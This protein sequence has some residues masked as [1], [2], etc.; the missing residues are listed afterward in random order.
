MKQRRKF[1]AGLAST[2]VLARMPLRASVPSESTQFTQ[3]LADLAQAQMRR[4]P[5]TATALG[6]DRGSNH[7]LRSRLSDQSLAGRAASYRQLQTEL[8]QL[9]AV[10]RAGLLHQQQID[11][12][13]AL[14]THRSDAA[15]QAFGFGGATFGPT[16][17]VVSQL[18]GA[19]QSIPDFLDTQH[20]IGNKDD[21]EAY[22]HRIQAFGQQVDDQTERMRQDAVLGVVP[23]DFIIDLAIEQMTKTAVP[24][25][26]SLI[27]RSILSR[28]SK[29]GLGGGYATQA[30]AIYAARV[31][32]SL[33]R[34]LAY[35]RALRAK[36]THEAGVWKLP[37]G[38]DF[39]PIALKATTTANVSPAEVHRFGLDQASM[40]S[41]RLD[42]QLRKQGLSN[43]TVGERMAALYKNP[44]QLYPNT[45]AGRLQAINYC[46]GRLESI[47]A[48]LPSVF[49]RL[50][51]YRFEVQRAPVQTEAGAPAAYNQT[52][53]IDGSRPG[54]IYFNLH[55]T[56]D[57]LKFCLATTV[58]HEGLPGHQLEGGLMLSNTTLPLIRKMMSFSGY[59][60]GWALYA[61]QLAEEIGM[62][63]DDPLGRLGYLK[64]MLFRANRCVVD[65][66]IHH[67]RWTREQ[68]VRRLIEQEGE[69]PGFA[70]REIERYCVTPGQAC[71][72]KI[73]HS[74]LNDLRD[75]AK[76]RQ[77]GKFDLKNYHAA[78][79][80]YGP[81]PLVVLQQ[82]GER[83]LHDES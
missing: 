59:G 62:Y 33:R 68:G 79:L 67:L 73:G 18:S 12:D 78:V 42:A 25:S 21:A 37:Q 4:D 40:L 63:D 32:P 75:L 3:L 20:E 48:K 10:N 60:E 65:T 23:P 15:I 14:F 45:D 17:Y 64:F 80:R 52:P 70:E 1:L 69:T 82:I 66:G 71:S 49:A 83:W 76:A 28:A 54:M 77:G 44:D 58:Y 81:V 51:S 39:Y 34:Q 6:F 8:A 35:M 9:E 24:P 5:E 13:C 43:G 22:L 72:Y 74:V 7:E 11:L 56:Q 30:A 29:R 36:A 55:Y 2:A 38:D 41:S 61:E 26:E 19:Y 16:P 53:S 46:N 47:R 57:W 27:V 50:P 31:L